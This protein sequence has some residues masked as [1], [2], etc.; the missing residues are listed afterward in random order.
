[1]CVGIVEQVLPF[2]ME[3]LPKFINRNIFSVLL[4][5]KEVVGLAIVAIAAKNAFFKFT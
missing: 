1:M 3:N 2:E 5:S 4:P